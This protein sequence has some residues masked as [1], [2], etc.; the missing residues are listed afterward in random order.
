MTT[1]DLLRGTRTILRPIVP[2]DY[3]A[4][5]RIELSGSLLR[6][7]RFGGTT[8]PPEEY[9]ALLWRGVHSQY[10][11]ESSTSGGSSAIALVT[12]YNMDATNGHCYVA[13]LRMADGVAASS[14]FIEGFAV[15]VE[16]LFRSTAIRK[17]YLEAPEYNV[18]EFESAV[19]T[20]LLTEEARLKEHR[21]FD[22]RYWDQCILSIT[23]NKWDEIGRFVPGLRE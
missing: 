13:A 4:L 9:A 18:V 12:S 5:Y 19:R 20:G 3:E 23:R 15:F 21:Y 1:G 8:P 11:V 16:S 22:G 7:W 2:S 17:V 10:L 14:M 6:S